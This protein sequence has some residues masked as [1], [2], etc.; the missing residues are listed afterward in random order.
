VVLGREREVIDRARIVEI[1]VESGYEYRGLASL[2]G[3]GHVVWELVFDMGV[4]YIC[5]L[6]QEKN[7]V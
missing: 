5:T 1:D 4:K 3:H 6:C 7:I 2:V